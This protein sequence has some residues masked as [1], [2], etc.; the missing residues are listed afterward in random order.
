MIAEMTD[1]SKPPVLCD[2]ES[3]GYRCDREKGHGSIH[4]HPERNGLG[5]DDWWIYWPHSED[6]KLDMSGRPWTGYLLVADVALPLSND[7]GV[8]IESEIRYLELAIEEM[9]HRYT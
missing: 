5:H 1:L 4:H 9:Y 7:T 2:A 3:C 8:V 6:E